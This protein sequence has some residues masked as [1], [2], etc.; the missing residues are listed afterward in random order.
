M[1]DHPSSSPAIVGAGRK[2]QHKAA[3]GAMLAGMAL[4]IYGWTRKSASGAALGV[5]GV[6]IALKAASAGPITDLIGTE[7]TT[8]CSFMI[9][10][11]PSELYV[12]WKDFERAPQWMEETESITKIDDRHVRWTRSHPGTGTL[13]WTTEIT[14]DVPNQVLAWRIVPGGDYDVRGRVEFGELGP[15]RGTE[16]VSSLTYRLHAGLLHSA[17]AMII[18]EDPQRKVRENLL[19]FKTLMEAGETATVHGKTAGARKINPTKTEGRVAARREAGVK[20]RVTLSHLTFKLLSICSYVG[21][22]WSN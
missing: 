17:T 4:S 19:R 15:S 3:W 20:G 18:G 8:R 12:A 16:V 2:R 22:S 5:A 14:E 7:I 11:D 10:R 13:E 21:R 6:A 9:M 1:E